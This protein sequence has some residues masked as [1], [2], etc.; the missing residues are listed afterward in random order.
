MLVKNYE[1]WLAV[2]K[3]IRKIIR[4]FFAHLFL[5]KHCSV[6]LRTRSSAIVV[7]ADRTRLK[8]LRDI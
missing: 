5:S 2:D 6:P 3:V 8:L 7:I 1:N 4:L